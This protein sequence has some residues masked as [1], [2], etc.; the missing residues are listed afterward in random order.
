M[1]IFKKLSDNGVEILISDQFYDYLKSE[2]SELPKVDD[3]ILGDVFDADY[4]LSIGGDGT[5]LNTAKRVGNKRIP[6]LGI[7]T[8]RL[9]YL[10]ASDGNDVDEVIKDLLEGNF[11]VEDRNQLSLQAF[12]AEMDYPYALNEIS[13][14]KRDI[15]AMLHIHVSVNGEYLNDYQADGLILSTATGSTAYSLS[16]GGPILM[17]ENKSFI[18]VPIASHS[19][20]V[21]PI[22][23]DESAVVDIQV[24]SRNKSFLVSLDGRPCNV[25]SSAVLHI[26]QADFPVRIIRRKGQSFVQTLSS[27]MMWGK[28]LRH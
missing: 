14:T 16:V 19:L 1:R 27:K 9:G 12:E 23:L 28:D 4:A 26:S 8:G 15:S 24:E 3:F 5:F 6:I 17:P 13:I 7:N 25:S 18:I 11:M 10:S 20:T 22:V 21:R 2:T